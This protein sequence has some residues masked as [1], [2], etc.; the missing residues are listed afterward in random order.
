MSSILYISLK[1]G[2]RDTLQVTQSHTLSCLIVVSKSKHWLLVK[3]EVLLCLGYFSVQNWKFGGISWVR[4]E[5]VFKRANHLW[6]F[7]P[8]AGEELL[9]GVHPRMWRDLLSGHWRAW[10][11]CATRTFTTATQDHAK[12]EK[13]AG[14][15]ST[16][17]GQLNGIKHPPPRR[18]VAPRH[19][20]NLDGGARHHH[21]GAPHLQGPPP[22]LLRQVPSELHHV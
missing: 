6:L 12:R 3:W 4:I 16:S 11:R 22:P 8:L 19:V 17:G 14:E 9:T 10:N 5:N 20:L 1:S 13:R 21:P 18:P 15:S 7:L 2:L